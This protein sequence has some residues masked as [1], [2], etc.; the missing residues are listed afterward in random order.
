MGRADRPVYQATVACAS[1][2]AVRKN[3]CDGGWSPPCWCIAGARPHRW[4]HRDQT[5]GPFQRRPLWPA[6]ARKSRMP[7]VF[8]STLAWHEELAISTCCIPPSKSSTDDQKRI[9]AGCA[10][11]DALPDQIRAPHA[12]LG[13]VPSDAIQLCLGLFCSGN[14]TFGEEQRRSLA[15]SG[16]SAGRTCARSTSRM[17]LG[18]SE[19]GE[20]NRL[21]STTCSSCA[22][23]RAATVRTMRRSLPILPSA[24]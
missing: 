19:S 8:S 10:G 17:I 7:R 4:C 5:G 16:G 20:V 1:D 13:I 21:R 11:G 24:G 18:S 2:P 9:A 14:F 23:T 15:E 3:A 22:G 12:D 6:P